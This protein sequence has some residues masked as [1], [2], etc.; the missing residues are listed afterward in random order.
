MMRALRMQREHSLASMTD[1][2]ERPKF[3]SSFFSAMAERAERKTI[4]Q[5]ILVPI[6]A[7]IVGAA[8]AYW[9]PADFW[10]EKNMGVATSVY[11]GILTLNGLILAISWSAFSRIY[12]TISAPKFSA[13]LQRNELL[14]KYLVTLTFIH[15]LQ[16]FSII[17]SAS[18]LVI[19]LM[20]ISYLF[21]DR[22]IFGLIVFGSIFAIQQAT[23]AVAIMNDL[24]WQKATFDEHEENSRKSKVVPIGG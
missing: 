2:L 4:F 16:L 1:K 15:G 10:L 13:F 17:V 8:T 22:S 18:G 19:L 9:L 5:G 7:A 14:N 23:S 12:E 20:D 24:V 6:V 3:L 11:V 21:I